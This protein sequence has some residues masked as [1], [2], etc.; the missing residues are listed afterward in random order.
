MRQFPTGVALLTVGRAEATIGMTVN[1][2]T[3]VSLDPPLVLVCVHRRARV[4]RA[5]AV[6]DALTISFLGADQSW[7]VRRF[8]SRAR[9]DGH[10]AVAEMDGCAGTN[11]VPAPGQALGVLEC[12]LD[13]SIPIG[14]HV[15]LIGLVVHATTRSDRAPQVFY[16]GELTTVPPAV[17]TREE[18]HDE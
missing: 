4:A 15:L 18:T 1:S 8:A 14:D 12:V 13:R 10:A 6:G 3:S 5:V 9:P 2:F 11:G 7:L 17:H 16:R